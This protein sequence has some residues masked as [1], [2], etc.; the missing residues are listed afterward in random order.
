MYGVLIYMPS[1]WLITDAVKLEHTAG[2][3]LARF[4]HYKVTFFFHLL[5]ILLYYFLFFGNKS[6]NLVHIPTQ[7]MRS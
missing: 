1:A 7:G 2:M 4:L 6:Q 3:T 5:S